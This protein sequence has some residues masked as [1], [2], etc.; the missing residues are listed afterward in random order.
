MNLRK[1][2][3]FHYFQWIIKNFMKF[4]AFPVP[5]WGYWFFIFP[6]F[7]WILRIFWIFMKDHN[8]LIFEQ[9]SGILCKNHTFSPDGENINIPWDFHCFGHGFSWKSNI[10]LNLSIFTKTQPVY[11][12]YAFS[13]KNTLFAF[14]ERQ[15]IFFENIPNYLVKCLPRAT[16][17]ALDGNE[18]EMQFSVNPT[19]FSGNKKKHWN[20]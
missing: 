13:E 2:Q 14:S 9:K 7:S 1:F 20:P 10:Q 16:F 8:S 5:A 6:W 11:I 15:H 4:N 3:E 18:A 12:K 17:P 19:Y